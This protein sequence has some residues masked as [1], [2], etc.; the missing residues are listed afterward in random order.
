MAKRLKIHNR[1]VIVLEKVLS[2]WWNYHRNIYEWSMLN[3]KKQEV[4]YS[5]KTLP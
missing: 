5:R 4:P 1:Q 2:D 3:D